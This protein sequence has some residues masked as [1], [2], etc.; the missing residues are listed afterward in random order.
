[1]N[2]L[3]ANGLSMIHLAAQGDAANTLY[4]FYMMELDINK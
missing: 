3:N 2:L 1:M 4:Y